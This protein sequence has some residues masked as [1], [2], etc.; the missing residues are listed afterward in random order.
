MSLTG[1]A[2]SLVF[3]AACGLAL[4]RAPIYGL[5]AY[6]VVLF[7]QPPARW[8]GQGIL[9]PVRW[10]LI[11]AIVTLLGL[12]IH[13]SRATSPV[14]PFLRQPFVIGYLLFTA[15]LVIQ[16]PWE[17]TGPNHWQMINYYLKYLL[18]MYLIYA[19]VD[20]TD[21]LKWFLWAYVAGC[22]YLAW[23]AYSSYTGWRFDSFGGAGIGEANAGALAITTGVMIGASMFLAGDWKTRLVLLACF[24]FLVNGITSTVSRSGFLAILAGGVAFNVFT[25]LRWKPRVLVLSVLGAALFLM[26]T[27][28]MY[29]DR[30]RSLQYGGEEVQGVDT[31]SGRLEIIRAQ[32][33]MF[34][35]H[36]L[37]CGHKCTD[38]LSSSY[39][40][41]EM[42]VQGVGERSS[43]NSFLSMLVDHG[44]VGA[45]FYI[46]ML[47]WIYTA[48]RRWSRISQGRDD[49]L[50]YLLPGLAASLASMTV[51]DMF[52]PYMRYEIRFWLLT[53]TMVAIDLMLRSAKPA[54][55]AES[56]GHDA[57]LE[58]RHR[59]ELGTT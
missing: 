2:F 43:H 46:A 34:A 20:T 54:G 28:Q 49:F 39:M 30:I 6:T 18:A 32:L 56:L 53:T 42:L 44:V 7:V 38:Y 10:A 11:A 19:C 5:M 29:W 31:G 50:R 15:W 3:L 35:D 1:L 40:N 14:V 57:P 59:R 37:G 27:N 17:L 23:I 48:L 25:P 58:T 47:L 51:A 21:N 4:V 55:V 26:L 45:A 8:W 41:Q 16:L 36:P 9:L 22:L 52:V 13:R 24:P 12:W 33:R